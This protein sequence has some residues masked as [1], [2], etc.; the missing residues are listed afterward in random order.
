MLYLMLTLLMLY[1]LTKDSGRDLT[2]QNSEVLIDDS[3][4]PIQDTRQVPTGA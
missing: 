2:N 4:E 1:Q 3:V